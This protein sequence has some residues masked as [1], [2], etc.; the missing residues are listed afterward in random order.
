V[1][2]LLAA[3][4]DLS[5]FARAVAGRWYG[6]RSSAEY[7]GPG[8]PVDPRL[9]LHD[10]S[11]LYLP[12]S[13]DLPGGGEGHRRFRLL[14]L[15][16]LA[17]VEF[18]TYAF[19]I[20]EARRRSPAL[21]ARPEVD[22]ARRSDFEAFYLH[23]PDRDA[24][25]L[26]FALLEPVR[27]EEALL[28]DYP[29]AAGDLRAARA[30]DLAARPALPAGGFA[31]MT[32]GLVR[33]GLGGEIGPEGPV[34]VV[35]LVAR[36]RR[37]GADVYD[38]A[39]AVAV[40][41]ARLEE[42]GIGP[43]GAA[44]PPPVAFRGRPPIEWLQREDR[45]ERWGWELAALEELQRESTGDDMPGSAYA[46]DALAEGDKVELGGKDTQGPGARTFAEERASLAKA[47]EDE[48]SALIRL[49]GIDTPLD[50][51]SFRYPEWDSVERRYL[52]N[53]CRV[54]DLRPDPALDEEVGELLASVGPHRSEV[55]RMFERIR[56]SSLRPVPGLLDGDEV[57]VD[58]LIGFQV[59]RRR[60]AGP[61][62]RIYRKRH[63]VA[64][65]VAVA[66]LLDLS[67][68]TGDPVDE[69][70]ER[71][72][73]DVDR[74]RQTY[75]EWMTELATP[76]PVRRTVIDV[77]R[78]SFLLMALALDSLGDRFALY[79]FSGH[80][81]ERVEF[82]TI[83]DLQEA[84]T[85]ATIRSLAAVKPRK[86]TRMGPAIRHAVRKLSRSGS[87]LPLLIIVS[88]GYPQDVDYGPE[89]SDRR[90][91]IEDSA[92]AIEEARL[93]GVETFCV[94]V[95]K[96]GQDYLREMLPDNRYLVIE[97]VEGLPSALAKVYETLTAG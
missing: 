77:M 63:V 6:V 26:L 70:P 71:V 72:E 89:R 28:R 7:D 47:I 40:L 37:E 36:L 52:P 22:A 54:Y 93:G 79:G 32:E 18:G 30:D 50:A 59:E 84:F 73:P 13:L 16:Q 51:P 91:G 82:Y 96:S 58:A 24:A 65:D 78:E 92:K 80:G 81:K 94:T 31:R 25:R 87:G 45:V 38:T 90:Y 34:P 9:P 43:D 17:Y 88:D 20:A 35:D 61:E 55:R 33:L 86:A 12:E 60:G 10:R 21:A 23:F 57:D 41:V 66:L 85:P 19:D 62:P 67:A 48:R 76:F 83:K 46:P 5:M 29:G 64:R 74:S 97:D 44:E 75:E 11:N 27:L 42:A 8:S 69:E 53:H 95:D 2:S 3:E 15:V 39:D 56:P 68:S 14:A 1:T 49:A 4:T